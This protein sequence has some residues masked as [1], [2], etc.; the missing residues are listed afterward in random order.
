MV[1]IPGFKKEENRNWEQHQIK[2]IICFT[3]IGLNVLFTLTTIMLFP[4]VAYKRHRFAWNEYKRAFTIQATGLIVVLLV[5]VAINVIQLADY[6]HSQTFY[7]LLQIPQIAAVYVFV[8]SK[9]P[10]DLFKLFN[11]RPDVQFSIYQYPN[12]FHAE[13]K[14]ALMKNMQYLQQRLGEQSGELIA[15]MD[16]D[17]ILNPNEAIRRAQLG[18]DMKFLVKD[19]GQGT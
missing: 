7:Y 1:A 11:K 3:L 10:K 5:N 17:D 9:Q 2:N 16:E 15:Q 12:F 14:L 4:Y 8:L 13:R 6:E 19:C 18:I